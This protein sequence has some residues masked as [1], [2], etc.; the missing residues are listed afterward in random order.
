MPKRSAACS[1]FFVISLNL[2]SSSLPTF[3]AQYFIPD[4]ILTTG[5]GLFAD[6][7]FLLAWQLHCKPPKSILQGTL[8]QRSSTSG[9]KKKKIMSLQNHSFHWNGR[10]YLKKYLKCVNWSFFYVLKDIICSTVRDAFPFQNG[11]IFGKVPNG[12]WPPAPPSFSESC[13]A[14]F[15]WNSWPKYRL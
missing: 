10:K 3:L 7:V 9:Q 8:K 1:P 4:Q 13:V 5:P 12:L 11:W 14:N 15:F 2:H 6:W